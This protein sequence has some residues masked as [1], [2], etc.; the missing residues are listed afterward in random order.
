MKK[1]VAVLIGAVLFLA[2]WGVILSWKAQ[3]DPKDLFHWVQVG[4]ERDWSSAAAQGVAEAQFLL[5]ITLIR[6]N[7][8]KGID[9]VPWLSSLPVVGR[10]YFEKVSYGID[11]NADPDQL[12]E[13]C[14]WIKKSA[15]QGYAPAQE[16]EKLFAG[17]D[18][19][20]RQKEAQ[21]K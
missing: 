11:G 8:F 7:L 4:R 2:G 9:R 21:T 10:R 1:Q 16:A 17:R 6:S 14:R 15:K 5:G 19:E 20:P 13:A 3:P 12:A 18:I